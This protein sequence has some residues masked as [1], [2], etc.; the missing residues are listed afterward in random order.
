MSVPEWCL[1]LLYKG[2]E[3][4]GDQGKKSEKMTT[5]RQHGSAPSLAA[6]LLMCAVLKCSICHDVYNFRILIGI[7]I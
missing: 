5:D 7:R 3:V 2:F 1:M 6:Q 4:D